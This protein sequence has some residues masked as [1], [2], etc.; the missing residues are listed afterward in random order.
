MLLFLTSFVFLLPSISCAPVSPTLI[1]SSAGARHNCP[2]E[3]SPGFGQS[4][5]GPKNIPR[6]IVYVQ[7]QSYINGEPLS[8]L[9]LLEHN[10]GVTHIIISSFHVNRPPGDITLNDD[11]PNSTIYDK[12]VCSN[13]R[14]SHRFRCSLLLS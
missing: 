1:S 2:E 4:N 10:T 3:L 8:L 6:L 12:V 9:P 14:I 5:N 13:S 7:H 11:P